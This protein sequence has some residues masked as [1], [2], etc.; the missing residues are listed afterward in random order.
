ML[1]VD[2]NFILNL[3]HLLLLISSS[4]DHSK[5]KDKCKFWQM[6]GIFNLATKPGQHILEVSQSVEDKKEEEGVRK[7]EE[8]GRYN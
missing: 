1:L 6:K 8:A 4:K 2:V 3:A 7:K 5:Q